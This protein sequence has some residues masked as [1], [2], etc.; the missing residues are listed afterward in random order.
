MIAATGALATG[1]TTD[2]LRKQ[3]K[4]QRTAELQIQ[5][6]ESQWTIHHGRTILQD[7]HWEE[8]RK[9]AN[10]VQMAPQGLA[11]HHEAARLLA[12]WE[13]M[14]CPTCTGR[15]WT[16]AEIQEAIDRGPHQS[17]LEPDALRHFADEVKD[18]V[19]KG[20]AR[21]VLWDEI[22]GNH[23]R[24]LKVSPV[25]AIPH[26]SRAYRSILDLSFS[27]RLT[28]GG[29]LPS[30]NDTTTKLAPRGAVD[31][32]GHSLKRIVHAFAKVEDDAVILM[33]KGDIQDGFWRLNCQ[34]GEEWNF[35]YVLPQPAGA[36]TRLVVPTSLQMGWVESPPYFSIGP[37]ATIPIYSH[38]W[39]L[40][41]FGT[42]SK[43]MSTTLLQRSYQQRRRKFCTSLGAYFMASTMFSQRARM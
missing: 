16:T 30:V 17:A 19:E 22:K 25:A 7:N 29:A 32:L 31:Q 11:L 38:R 33:A 26:K 43:Y 4:Y 41:H 36:P 5:P 34:H 37:G 12:E 8:V 2:A 40:V 42:S 39:V 13:Q 14:G 15:D 35:S 9:T 1:A 28:E 18:K 6:P 23:P 24:Q 10:E 27:L 3:N 20:Q 21:V